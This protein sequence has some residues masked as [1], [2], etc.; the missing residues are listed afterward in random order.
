MIGMGPAIPDIAE[1]NRRTSFAIRAVDFGRFNQ[2]AKVV[3]EFQRQYTAGVVSYQMQ[4]AIIDIVHRFRKQITDKAVTD[5][6][7]VRSKGAD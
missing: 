4:K 1:F 2:T 7:A 3:A 5:F 6:A